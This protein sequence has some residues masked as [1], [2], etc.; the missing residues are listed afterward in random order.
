MLR[1]YEILVKIRICGPI[2]LTNGSG[3]CCFP[4]WS[5]RRQQK[6]IFAY[7][8]LKVHLHY[9][10]KIRIIKRS[11]KTVGINMFFLLSFLLEGS[12][13]RYRSISLTDGSGSGRSKNIRIRILFWSASLVYTIRDDG[14]HSVLDQD[15]LQ[16]SERIWIQ[17][18]KNG[19]S[20]IRGSCSGLKVNKN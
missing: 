15:W 18:S 10:L 8:F 11:R 9:F 14:Y 5:S 1:I 3:S 7:Y 17:G 6:V 4:Q 13:A 12:G 19:S 2:P 16:T 20:R